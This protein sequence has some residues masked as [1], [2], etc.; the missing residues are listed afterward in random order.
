MNVSTLQARSPYW[1]RHQRDKYQ[2]G[3]DLGD[4]ATRQPRQS[5]NLVSLLHANCQMTSTSS[6]QDA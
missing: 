4:Y 6:T 5:L 2:F 3:C 1:T